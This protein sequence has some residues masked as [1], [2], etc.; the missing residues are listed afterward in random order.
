LVKDIAPFGA[1]SYP[2]DFT[3]VNGT[4]FFKA[5][6]FFHGYEL[7][8][9]DGTAAG[10]VMVKDINPG[11]GDSLPFALTNVSGTLF[12][13]ATDGTRGF[14]LWRSDGS[15]AGTVLV[16]DINAGAGSSYPEYLTNV[17]GTLFFSANNG[18][19]G[20]E[21]WRSDG[22]TPGTVLIKNI[23]PSNV[24]SSPAG[25]TNVNGTLFFSANNG[26]S[27]PEL[28][29]SNGTAPGTVLVRD[30]NPGPAGSNPSY[31]TNV[32]GVLYFS[33][34][35]GVHGVEPWVLR[36]SSTPTQTVLGSSADPTVYSQP[37]TLT[38]TVRPAG[39]GSGT[40]TGVVSFK[41]GGATLGNAILDATG[42]ATLSVSSLALGNHAITGSYAG[43]GAFTGSGAGPLTQKVV[44][45]TVAVTIRSSS[46][47]S[48]FGQVVNLRAI[49]NAATPG[50]GFPTGTVTFQ[51]GDHVLGTGTLSVHNGVD[52]AVISVGGLAV[53]NNTIIAVY[54]GDQN[55]LSGS[56]SGSQS[57]NP[58]GTRTAV[59]SSAN[60]SP[61]GQPVTFTATVRA[62]APGSGTPTG[63]VTFK[64]GGTFLGTGTLNKVGQATFAT[65]G[66]SAG[67]HQITA[68]Y[69]GDGSFF[70]SKSPGLTESI[71][72]GPALV[73]PVYSILWDPPNSAPVVG[74]RGK[75][76]PTAGDWVDDVW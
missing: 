70:G 69:S 49:V 15:A 45:D 19:S 57:V 32:G 9:T 55:F 51:T 47:P 65:S 23:N 21:L 58:D 3:N 35:D 34:D 38:A 16:K 60:P 42:R 40:P 18:V 17:G 68:T 63:T 12:F 39:G 36:T 11:R 46:N 4:L 13:Q 48:V 25:L 31:L 73:D 66:L 28:W 20:P 24:G 2:A 8:R 56:F 14:E 29:Q 33:A 1:N 10:T 59:G 6:D 26:T 74:G 27:G 54:N 67:N 61:L 37:V 30:I 22:T 5:T 71:N 53:G 76:F 75:H 50:T 41:D 72:L 44:Q 43:D 7:W 64:D 62:L 52:R